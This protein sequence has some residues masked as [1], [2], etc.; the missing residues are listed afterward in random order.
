MPGLLTKLGLFEAVEDL[1]ENLNDTEDMVAE[2]IIN[3][4]ME[5]LPENREIMV[6][7]IIQEMVNNSLKHAQAHEIKLTIDVLPGKLDIIYTDDGKGF[8]L[9]QKL[10]SETES[11]G[12]KSIQSRTNFLNGKMD[13]ESSPGNGVRYNFQVPV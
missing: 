10:E 5:R 7:R 12:L 2:C 4:E 13:M 1:F 8:D 3:G 9:R 11:I 6:Y